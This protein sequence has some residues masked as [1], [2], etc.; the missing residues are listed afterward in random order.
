MRL[1]LLDTD[2]VSNLRKPQPNRL[3]VEWIDA[4]SDEIHIPLQVVFEI[5]YGA[6]RLRR[7]GKSAKADGVEAW[8]ERLLAVSGPSD[9]ACPRADDARQQA[10]MFAFPAL[11]NFLVPEPR[12]TKLKFGSDII[13][14]AMA[15]VR[16]AVVV[17]FDED[18]LRIHQHFPL[19]GLFHPGRGEW[20]ID[21]PV[22]AWMPDEV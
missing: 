16:Q 4:N 8:L 19:P 1:Y 14:A 10:K 6:E 21:P 15:I 17:S 7:E 11:R 18:Y 5:Q 12:S 13:I 22:P 9:I 20:L 2:V 3:L